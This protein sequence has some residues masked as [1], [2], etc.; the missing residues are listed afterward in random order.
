MSLTSLDDQARAAAN[1]RTLAR[2][3]AAAFVAGGLL[4]GVEGFADVLSPADYPLAVVLGPAVLLMLV[5][6]LGYAAV[7]QER[8]GRLGTLA[9]ALVVPG[10]LVDAAG[11]VGMLGEPI[12]IVGVL[13]FM[14]GSVLYGVATFRARVFPR[15]CALGFIVPLPLP[16][17]VEVAGT[18]VTG[19]MKT[20][21]NLVS[22]I[23][24]KL[25]V[26]DR[27]Q[28]A[29]RARDAGL[30]RPAP[31]PGSRHRDPAREPAS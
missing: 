18:I 24:A 16:L 13:T 7:Q 20:V 8:T 17:V 25:Q 21:R 5:G 15:W 29:L 1:R 2:A 10:L 19:L 11:K 4:F 28:A 14:A 3:G 23:L 12:T 31:P 9:L 27:A 26:S 30:S 22:S 6:Y